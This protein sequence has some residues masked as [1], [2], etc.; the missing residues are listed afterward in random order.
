MAIGFVSERWKSINST[1]SKSHNWGL[2]SLILNYL[3]LFP[4][5]WTI[6]RKKCVLSNKIDVKTLYRALEIVW[7]RTVYTRTIY[8]VHK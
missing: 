1:E 6:K 2:F 3:F 7:K 4:D 8:F 5:K